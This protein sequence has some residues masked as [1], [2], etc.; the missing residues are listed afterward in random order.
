MWQSGKD[1]HRFPQIQNLRDTKHALPTDTQPSR[2]NKPMFTFKYTHRSADTC[3]HASTPTVLCSSEALPFSCQNGWP[4]LWG[5]GPLLSLTWTAPIQHRAG[6]REEDFL[7]T[8]ERCMLIPVCANG[9]SWY[10]GKPGVN[11]LEQREEW[12]KEGWDGGCAAVCVW[13]DPAPDRFNEHTGERPF[14]SKP[15]FS[16]VHTHTIT[17][18]Q[19]LQAWMIFCM[20]AKFLIRKQC[21]DRDKNI[22]P[23][24]LI[25]N[26]KRVW[27]Y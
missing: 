25:H 24:K 11:E 20:C 12:G 4:Y 9:K 10:T 16:R 2:H 5:V 17:Q 6:G 14:N 8:D 22:K 13:S 1:F 18:G 7:I 26:T 15:T 21:T 27:G 19:M 3:T 23:D